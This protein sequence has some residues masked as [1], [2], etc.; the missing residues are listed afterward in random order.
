MAKDASGNLVQ[1]DA[2]GQ[3]FCDGTLLADIPKRRL[4]E[5]FHCNYFIVSQVNPHV[6]PFLRRS[7]LAALRTGLGMGTHPVSRTLRHVEDW[8]AI[9][10]RHDVQ[11]LSKFKLLPTLFGMNLN[12]LAHQNYG[13]FG[14][15]GM[16][17]IP[18]TLGFGETPQA[19]LNPTVRAMRHYLLDGQ[20]CVWPRC[21]ELDRLMHV[22]CALD[23]CAA[24]LEWLTRGGGGSPRR[25]RTSKRKP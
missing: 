14:E 20:R 2:G 24:R 9:N 12:P 6:A 17:L 25:T 22:E 3:F 13:Q 4:A 5:L 15:A 1:F 23:R 16:T 7:E 8:L 21:A 18:Q 19:I 11:I 10:I